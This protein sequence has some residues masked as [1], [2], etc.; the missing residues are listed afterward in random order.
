MNKLSWCPSAYEAQISS[1]DVDRNYVDRTVI[2]L[3]EELKK[4]KQETL[5]VLE[6]VSADERPFLSQGLSN[7]E[8]LEQQA[9]TEWQNALELLEEEQRGSDLA[10]E[11][12]KA[13]MDEL[14]RTT[15]TFTAEIE[16]LRAE[17]ATLE[18][19]HY[20]VFLSFQLSFSLLERHCCSLPI[21]EVLQAD[22]F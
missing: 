11:I 10:R 2:A 14:I 4:S 18:V 21:L 7:I 5:A 6:S 13:A 3:H 1:A 17:R 20:A 19:S 12:S 22:N 15:S 16:H 8:Q 9:R